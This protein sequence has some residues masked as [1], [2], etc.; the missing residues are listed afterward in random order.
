MERASLVLWP[1]TMAIRINV[2][3]PRGRGGAGRVGGKGG[4]KFATCERREGKGNF[5]FAQGF[6]S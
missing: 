5:T 3:V 2:N 4:R 6:E 1:L